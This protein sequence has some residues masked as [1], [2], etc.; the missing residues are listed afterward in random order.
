MLSMA[1]TNHHPFG[2]MLSK[3][4]L[5]IYLEEEYRLRFRL[6]DP[7][8]QRYEVPVLLQT[9]TK[10]KVDHTM[11]D[12]SVTLD[13]FGLVLTRKSSGTVVFNSTIAPLLY[14]D[15]FLQVFGY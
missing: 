6:T 13:R 11:F 4:S 2:P 7:N 8:S 3:V 9:T 5:D 14:G 15:Q 10:A 12:L 1:S